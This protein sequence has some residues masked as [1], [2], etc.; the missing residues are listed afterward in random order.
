VVDLAPS[1]PRAL[2]APRPP[3]VRV[4]PPERPAG[5]FVA[6]PLAEVRERFVEHHVVHVTGPESSVASLLSAIGRDV[7]HPGEST[8]YVDARGAVF[9]DILQVLFELLCSGAPTSIASPE[10]LREGL[11]AVRA[12]VLLRDAILTVS[13]SLTLGDILRGCLV[14]LAHEHEPWPEDEIVR[15]GG[16]G[17]AHEPLA[18]RVALLRPSEVEALEV[19]LAACGDPIHERV[20][21]AVLDGAAAGAL[22]TLDELGLNERDE[23]WHRASSLLCRSIPDDLRPERWAGAL[24]NAIA[25]WARDA[26][27]SQAS[28]SRGAGAWRRAH[29]WLLQAESIAA[30]HLQEDVA[31]ARRWG[32]WRALLLDALDHAEATADTAGRAWALHQLGSRAL[33]LGDRLAARACLAEARDLR[34]RTG[35]RAG[36]A[37]TQHNL[38]LASALGANRGS[39][40]SRL[41]AWVRG[42]RRQSLR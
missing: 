42:R 21:T 34:W 28:W 33:C 10:E 6:G 7:A 17:E 39:R 20:L 19:L 23:P 14:V 40:R 11:G 38:V 26:R 9:S 24:A 2:V 32:A 8:I 12:L 1:E 13:E 29:A 16:E 18:P 35:D 4:L 15:V 5:P 31:L 25:A 30:L 37:V 36:A 22:R 27:G 41:A 3:P